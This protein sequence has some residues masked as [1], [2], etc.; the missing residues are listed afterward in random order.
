[1][2]AWAVRVINPYSIIPA[3]IIALVFWRSLHIKNIKLVAWFV[4]FKAVG[5]LV[6]HLTNA[7]NNLILFLIYCTVEPIM[8][9]LILTSQNQFVSLRKFYV[10]ASIFTAVFMAICVFVQ[11]DKFPSLARSIQ[12]VFLSAIS[13]YHIYKWYKRGILI[14]YELMVLLSFFGYYTMCLVTRAG[15]YNAQQ[16]WIPTF[17]I[18][19]NIMNM[20]GNLMLAFALWNYVRGYA[21]KH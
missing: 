15:A 9:S 14:P 5:E 11:P 12:L 1:M 7:N 2:I 19:Q 8:I 17:Y 18:I 4:V 21:G 20:G 16:E 10:S 13:L 6:A 3:L